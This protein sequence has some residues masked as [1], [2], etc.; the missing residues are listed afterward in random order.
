MQAQRSVVLEVAVLA[1]A[2]AVFLATFQVRASYVD[3]AL[4]AGAVALIVA[5]SR[6]SRRLWELARP[7]VAGERAARANYRSA[8]LLTAAFTIAALAVLAVLAV[9][10]PPASAA[11]RPTL[12]RFFT[13]HLFAAMLLYFPWALLQQY[14]FQFYLFGRLLHLLPSVAAVAVTAMAFASVHFPRWPVMVVTL[15]AGSVWTQ[16][17]YRHRVLLP[18]AAS[19]AILGAALHYWVFGNDLLAAWS[20]SL[21]SWLAR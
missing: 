6:R 14:I 20:T 7:T 3:F 11:G 18:L 10:W 1:L 19:H 17:Y 21:P 13:L 16:I 8:V 2:T 4:A 5:S 15:V 12:E 9:G